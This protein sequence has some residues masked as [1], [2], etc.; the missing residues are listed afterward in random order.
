MSLLEKLLG[1]KPRIQPASSESELVPLPTGD[2]TIFANVM[3]RAQTEQDVH[4]VFA[5][6]EALQAHPGL[7]PD[8]LR[9]ASIVEETYPLIKK[10]REIQPLSTEWLENVGDILTTINDNSEKYVEAQ[11]GLSEALDHW[12]RRRNEDT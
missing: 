10:A 3:V 1:R 4:Q 12:E 2:T 5:G 8:V 11:E 6:F 7:P 9:I